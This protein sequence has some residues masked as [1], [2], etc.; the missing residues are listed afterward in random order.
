M[1]E[2]INDSYF[3]EKI[4]SGGNCR[5]LRFFECKNVS[6]SDLLD[7][8]N[9]PKVALRDEFE[10]LVFGGELIILDFG[11]NGVCALIQ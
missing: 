8:E 6:S 2:A 7:F 10:C 3:V 5:I 1:G 4:N 11:H 9:N